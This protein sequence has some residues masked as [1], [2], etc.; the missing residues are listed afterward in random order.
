MKHSLIILISII[1]LTFLYPQTV[2]IARTIS[3]SPVKVARQQSLEDSLDQI[4]QFN[5]K[6]ID[7]TIQTV[8]QQQT[9]IQLQTKYY[10]SYFPV[11]HL[12]KPTN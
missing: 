5:L 3:T 6:A 10:E 2:G 9:I 8:E 12:P 7:I 11:S 1:I 4:I